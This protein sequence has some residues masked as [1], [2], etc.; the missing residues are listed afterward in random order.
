MSRRLIE[1]FQLT[2]RAGPTHDLAV[3]KRDFYRPPGIMRLAAPPRNALSRKLP[4]RLISSGGRDAAG[5]MRNCVARLLRFFFLRAGARNEFGSGQD[6][7]PIR[8]RGPR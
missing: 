3:V 1:L 5:D 4:G 2:G 6:A 8:A 7:V